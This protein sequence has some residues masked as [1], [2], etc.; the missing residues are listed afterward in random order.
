[1]E[2]KNSNKNS[3]SSHSVSIRSWC[4]GGR[5]ILLNHVLEQRAVINNEL[6][7]R[8]F[9]EHSQLAFSQQASQML[10]FYSH[11]H[12]EFVLS[13]DDAFE[14][15]ASV[16]CILFP[17]DCYFVLTSSHSYPWYDYL[18]PQLL[19]KLPKQQSITQL[20]RVHKP[21]N[22]FFQATSIRIRQLTNVPVSFVAEEDW[23]QDS[24][25]YEY[26]WTRGT[27]DVCPW[28]SEN[29]FHSVMVN[30]CQG[31]KL[32]YVIISYDPI[33]SIS[34]R[35]RNSQEKNHHHHHRYENPSGYKIELILSLFDA[36]RRII[37]YLFF[38]CIVIWLYWFVKSIYHHDCDIF[39]ISQHCPPTSLL[40]F[41]SSSFDPFETCIN[42]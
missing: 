26:S 35:T 31:C 10:F 36:C 6:I 17:S 25:S 23:S 28:N 27:S 20:T 22:P 40:R 12:H 9:M 13:K 41:S 5:P 38:L 1:M 7:M 18:L 37:H 2:Q 32:V 19:H 29:D 39:P 3:Q 34:P 15:C 14:A 42:S 11:N 30:C 21:N 33:K 24:S 8:L 4:N 16:V